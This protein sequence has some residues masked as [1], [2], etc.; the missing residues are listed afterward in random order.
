MKIIPTPAG[1]LSAQW[2][3]V[4]AVKQYAPEGERWES[5]DQIANALGGGHASRNGVYQKLERA[6]DRGLAEKRMFFMRDGNVRHPVS[7]YR[8]ILKA[9]KARPARHCRQLGQI[10]QTKLP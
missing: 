8:A 4:L 6:V 2:A 9:A 5:L 3:G 7:H 1:A 10:V